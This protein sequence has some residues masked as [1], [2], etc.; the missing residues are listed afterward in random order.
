[1]DIENFIADR[2]RLAHPIETALYRTVQ[3]AL[4]NVVKH[5]RAKEVRVRI[6]IEQQLVCCT[7]KDDGA[8]FLSSDGP[9]GLG[10]VG[11]RERI[12]SLH[13][14]FEI[15]SRPGSGTELRVSIPLGENL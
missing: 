1:V 13:G 5:A 9:G 15:N 4:N 14:A 12:G 6:W 2:G 10:L 11:I 7:V 8:G 3:E